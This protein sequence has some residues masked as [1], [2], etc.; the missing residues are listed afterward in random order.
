MNED[1][2]GAVTGNSAGDD[3]ARDIDTRLP[4]EAAGLR[5]DTALANLYPEYSRS[6][7]Q[8]WIRDGRV[9]LDGAVPRP[10]ERVAGGE[11]LSIRVEPERE[12]RHA[13]EPIGLEIV[14]EDGEIIVLDKPAG[15]VVHPGAGN[16]SGTL[17]N[18]LL[19][20][21]PELEGV[22]RAGIVHRLD[23]DTSGLMVVARTLP[24]H[25]ALVSQLQARSVRREYLAL[26]RGALVSGGTVE[27]DIGRH[28]T[29][30][31]RMAVVLRGKPAITHYRIARRFHAHTLLDVRL[32][33]GRTHQIRV[34]MAHIRHP[35]TG[36]PVYGGRI[37]VPAGAS[38][39]LTE[40]LRAFRRQALHAA[41][42]GL[43]HPRTAV[44]MEWTVPM[45]ADMR[46]LVERLGEDRDGREA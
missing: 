20:H 40:A 28:P 26:V 23:R 24:A 3:G 32:E 11:S 31:T 15:R 1:E 29:Q 2:A 34:H 44:Q 14:Y 21:A 36:D 35:V 33:T 4:P 25:T 17:L 27:G 19:H 42:L 12:V 13:A 39:A 8:R 41:T 9:R 38:P 37:A 10:R 30:R 6:R 43:I 18:A 45:P 5:L 7:L 46:S 16:P 22:P